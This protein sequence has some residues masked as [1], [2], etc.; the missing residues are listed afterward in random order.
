MVGALVSQ[1]AHNLG[2]STC[3]GFCHHVVEDALVTLLVTYP[4]NQFEENNTLRRS[5]PIISNLR[6][7]NFFSQKSH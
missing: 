7:R 5:N 4:A 1:G 6:C 2:I 3:S